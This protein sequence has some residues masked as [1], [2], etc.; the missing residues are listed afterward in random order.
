MIE[1]PE[2]INLAKQMR[3]TVRGKTVSAVYPLPHPTN[4]AGLTMSRRSI[5]R[6]WPVIR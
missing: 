3:E 5:R 1:L 2:A 6:F 4:S